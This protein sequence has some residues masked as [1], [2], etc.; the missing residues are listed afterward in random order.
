MGTEQVN[1][2]SVNFPTD[3]GKEFL[4]LILY[5][6]YRMSS[7]F[8]SLIRNLDIPLFL[9]TEL[10]DLLGSFSVMVWISLTNSGILF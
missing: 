4:F 2:F 10:I 1:V 9:A 5:E 6:K 7:C 3:A 8:T